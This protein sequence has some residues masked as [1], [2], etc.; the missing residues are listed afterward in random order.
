MSR[1]AGEDP[2][3]A[4]AEYVNMQAAAALHATRAAAAQRG[5]FTVKGGMMQTSKRMLLAAKISKQSSD[6]DATNPT[7]GDMPA[8]VE[9]VTEAEAGGNT[10]SPPSALQQ[11]RASHS[12]ESHVQPNSVPV[13]QQQPEVLQDSV[14]SAEDPQRAQELKLAQ[15]R[16][17]EQAAAFAAREQALLS[18]LSARKAELA[19]AAF[20]A[21][22]QALLSE[23]S[24]QK[25]EPT[26]ADG[27]AQDTLA[28]E[29]AEAAEARRLAAEAKL[30]RDSMQRELA[31]AQ[32]S[33]A[34]QLKDVVAQ[35]R[36]D[37]SPRADHDT[38]L[39]A[40]AQ[41]EEILRMQLQVAAMELEVV[42]S[43]R[44][45]AADRQALTLSADDLE[46]PKKG[47]LHAQQVSGGM[48]LSPRD[49]LGPRHEPETEPEPEAERLPNDLSP[50]SRE[51]G[52][53]TEFS[54]R[55][56]SPDPETARLDKLMQ[57]L[58]DLQSKL[59]SEQSGSTPA[60]A[61]MFA[62]VPQEP[63]VQ[64]NSVPVRQQQPETLQD[65]VTSA[66]D[67]Q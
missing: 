11:T 36:Q 32:S 47:S 3:V 10:Y 5:W 35:V 43:K 48:S 12:Q 33:F 54:S 9:L 67:P 60:S 38:E 65:S 56:S 41:R 66:E 18:E 13:R 49:A 2:R 26:V 19:E 15:A 37:G 14:T 42:E 22:E 30:E 57:S 7:D 8:I 62:I 1:R 6:S 17:E 23:L 28:A 40:A 24:A 61:D 63:H 34:Q 25:A 51:A 64:P 44:T 20:A 39:H 21:R 4:Y 55:T 45:A 50:L 59:S 27:K 29:A 16:T 52:S 53:A 31:E 46:D 58:D